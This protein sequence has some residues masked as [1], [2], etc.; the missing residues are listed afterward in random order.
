MMYKLLA[1][2]VAVVHFCF[3]LFVI[4]G[5][6]LVFKW[7]WSIWLHL[8]VLLW[9]VSLEFSGWICPLTPLEN[10]LR[11]SGGELVYDGGFIAHYLIPM[12]YPAGLTPWHQMIL[13]TAL[14]VFNVVI[15]ITLW[16]WYKR[17]PN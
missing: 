12:I 4:F 3:I 15:Y 5:A 9:G 16:W 17:M 10:W 6:L 14:I 13:G 2:G 8:P 11:K 1:D 7:R